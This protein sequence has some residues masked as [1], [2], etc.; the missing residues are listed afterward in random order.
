MARRIR[1]V[2]FDMDGTLFGSMEPITTAFIETILEADGPRYM[3]D[4]I[5]EAFTQGPSERMLEHLLGRPIT[6]AEHAAYHRRLDEGATAMRPFSGRGRGARHA[7]RRG[8]AA[9]PVHRRRR[10]EPRPAA[11]EDRPA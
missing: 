11:V 4:Q 8:P 2:I 3:P 6:D 7:R 5:V 10:H 9:R 1:A